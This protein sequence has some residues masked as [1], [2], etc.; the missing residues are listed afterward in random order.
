MMLFDVMIKLNQQEKE[1]K[2]PEI[3]I[4]NE[5]FRELEKLAIGFD[6]PE[7]VI[8]RLI[9]ETK[10]RTMIPRNKKVY[11]TGNSERVATTPEMMSECYRLAKDIFEGRAE[12]NDSLD[13]LA[14]DMGMHRGSATMFIGAFTAMRTGERYTRTV[15]N[16]TTKYFL[17]QIFT[18]YGEDG[19]RMAL[20]AVWENI[21]YHESFLGGKKKGTRKIHVA[22][23]A[24]LENKKVCPECPHIFKGNGWDGIDA[25]W[26]SKHE[27]I[28]PYKEAWPLI[29][30]GQYKSQTQ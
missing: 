18:D 5:T 13:Y 26:K 7:N 25:H 2:M 14:T 15:S 6:T 21:V 11:S 24:N 1:N 17:E 23:S 12:L 4:K 30:S 16:P 3:T 20:N 8:E 9:R 22:F 29:Q 28:M 27:H 10:Q 19:L